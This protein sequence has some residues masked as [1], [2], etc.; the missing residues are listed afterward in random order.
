VNTE[1]AVLTLLASLP[2]VAA[3]NLFKV[4]A[5]LGFA[6]N[7]LLVN[8]SASLFATVRLGTL[9]ALAQMASSAMRA[10]GPLTFSTL[11]SITF[12]QQLLRGYLAW[13]VLAVVGSGGIL[14]SMGIADVE[15]MIRRGEVAERVEGRDA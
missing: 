3:S 11:L 13:I 14:A 12:Q 8:Q 4:F 1:T 9:N 15:G 5:S 6:S 7:M 2:A 10:I